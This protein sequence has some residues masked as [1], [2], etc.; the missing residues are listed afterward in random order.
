MLSEATAMDR[1][2]RS[3]TQRDDV[4]LSTHAYFRK[5]RYQIK[6][7]KPQRSP[8]SRPGTW[9]HLELTPRTP[10]P[11][12]ASEGILQEQIT[13][14][15]C[16]HLMSTFRRGHITHI[17]PWN[18]R[19]PPIQGGRWPLIWLERPSLRLKEPCLRRIRPCPS[20]CIS[21][22]PP[23]G[24]IQQQHRHS[25]GRRSRALRAVL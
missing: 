10:A 21:S 18:G 9:D 5:H 23:Q 12:A 16:T 2:A 13:T 8:G 6:R 11:E 1:Q 14:Q 24:S 17:W 25:L 3:F 20:N 7:F 4:L 19:H 15:R 22:V